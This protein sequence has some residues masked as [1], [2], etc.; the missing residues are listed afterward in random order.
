MIYWFINNSYSQKSQSEYVSGVV[1]FWMEQ[2]ADILESQSVVVFI[3]SKNAPSRV[4]LTPTT[5]NITAYLARIHMLIFSY[6][7]KG[8]LKS[9]IIWRLYDDGNGHER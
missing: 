6:F 7:D 8:S 2:G 4:Q 1:W 5:R 3:R 9:E